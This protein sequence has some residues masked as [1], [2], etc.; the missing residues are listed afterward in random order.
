MFFKMHKLCLI[1]GSGFV[2]R[3]F[4]ALPPLTTSSQIPIGALVGFCNMILKL[5]E[6][7]PADFWGV[8]FDSAEKNFRHDLFP[9]YKQNRLAA[10]PELT[11]QFPLIQEYCQA[12]HIPV[13]QMPGTEADDLIATYALAGKEK[14]WSVEIVSS[15]KDMMQLIQNNICLYDP[16][17]EKVF[18]EQEVYEK[19]GVFP[20]QMADF[21][22]L[23]G[24][25]SDNIS[26]L[27]GIGPKTAATWL[28]EF[29][30]L[31]NLLEN[32][33]QLTSLKKR[34]LIADHMD[35]I[36][37]C[38]KLVTLDTKLPLPLPLEALARQQPLHQELQI[39]LE[40]YE[41][42]NLKQRLIKKGLLSPKE[43]LKPQS[44]PILPLR[45]S[46][47]IE[48]SEQ[49]GWVFLMHTEHPDSPNKIYACFDEAQVFVCCPN[50]DPGLFSDLMTCPHILKI[51]YDAK[52][53]MHF[54]EDITLSHS[55][56][57]FTAFDDLMLLSYITHAPSSLLQAP[58]LSKSLDQEQE[59]AS[60][61]IRFPQSHRH[62]RH[63]IQKQHLHV[64][65]EEL[66]KPLVPV[67]YAMEKKGILIDTE[68]LCHLKS[69]WLK[70]LAD[71]EGSIHQEMGRSD[72]NLASSKQLGDVLFEDLAWKP[73]KKGKSG[74]YSTSVD[75]LEEFAAQGYPLAQKLIQF[76]Q[77]SKLESTYTDS[78]IDKIDPQTKRLSTSFNM[79]GTST[80]RLSSLNPNLQNIPIRTEEGRKI[81][82]AFCAQP[83]SVLG[84]FDY[85]QI[86]LRL[87]AELG[88]I[89]SLKSAFREDHDIHTQTAHHIFQVPKHEPVTPDQRRQ[90]KT[91]NFGILYGQSGFG[92]AQQ[93]GIPVKEAQKLI[94]DYFLAY[95]DILTYIEKTK[96]EAAKKG[97]VQTLWGRRCIIPDI[98]SSSYVLR[99][100]AERQAVNAPLQGTSADF[101]KKAMIQVANLIQ[102]FRA[103]SASFEVNLL[104]QIHDEL[105]IEMS[106]ECVEKLSPQIVQ[107][108]QNVAFLSIPLKVNASHALRWGE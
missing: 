56:Q 64:I 33:H 31:Q 36:L 67:L 6:Q 18:Q 106:C 104:L 3:A 44:V 39:F 1:D 12:F 28:T 63:D 13:I 59:C 25:S 68:Y 34:Q 50:E 103:L 102:D 90:A 9:G 87:L 105:I 78:L 81:R 8:C 49:K 107:V 22:T 20:H 2:F 57:N 82:Q 76:R 15:D 40:K 88:N 17:K 26:G 45:L 100:A 48:Q 27:P 96:T 16:L 29:G 51:V 97:F 52:K 55:S 74:A 66:E 86:E 73:S 43:E 35:L 58:N 37:Q 5:Q 62:L 91:V 95:P 98:Q 65:Y 41:L 80:G 19:W 83:G 94:D 85:S 79:V 101:M 7:R 93:L 70:Q 46:D 99:T 60:W 38:Q 32:H 77:L 84:F 75:V 24:D 42:A 23:V 69:S 30:S 4:H 21:Q 92:L 10:A 61:L 47:L 108:M 71:L 54:I 14:G 89:E 11:A 53:W 72:V